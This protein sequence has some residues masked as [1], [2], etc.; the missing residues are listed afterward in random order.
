MTFLL[1]VEPMTTETSRLCTWKCS[2]ISSQM[3]SFA[4]P[5]TGGA[6]TSTLKL[7]SGCGVTLS[8]LL[9]ACTLTFIL[10]MAL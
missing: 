1:F 5:S 10:M 2:A 7:P 3:A 4:A 6:L 8:R 9:R